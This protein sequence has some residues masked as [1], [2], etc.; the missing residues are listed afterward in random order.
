MTLTHCGL[1]TKIW[2][3]IGS[4]NGFWPNSFKLL[5]EPMLTSLKVFCGI[6]QTAISQ[7][8]INL[9]HNMYSKVIVLKWLPHLWGAKELTLPMIE[10][11]YSGLFGQYHVCW[12]PG[13]LSRQG[14]SRNDIDNIGWATCRVAAL[15]IWSSTEQNPRYETK[16]D[17]IFYN[18]QHNS[19]C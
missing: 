11:E 7:V 5:P 18:L 16:Y 8:L 4:G 14:I 15:W 1:L 10:T 6:H 17:Y 19:A 13:S 3:K 12:C 9:I 2:V